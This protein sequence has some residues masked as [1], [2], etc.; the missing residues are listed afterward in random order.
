MG[1]HG[2]ELKNPTRSLFANTL[3]FE[4][5]KFGVQV[6]IPNDILKESA[7]TSIGFVVLLLCLE[8]F[9]CRTVLG[10]QKGSTVHDWSTPRPTFQQICVLTAFG[11]S[12]PTLVVSLRETIQYIQY[13]RYRCEKQKYP[14]KVIA[15]YITSNITE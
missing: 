6:P 10:E 11:L 15:R 5:L 13:V 1:T 8:M 7:N 2:N 14:E 12:Q 4:A 9:C 3:G